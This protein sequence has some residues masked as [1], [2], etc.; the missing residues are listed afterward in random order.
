[1][2]AN[3]GCVIA[4]PCLLALVSVVVANA[5]VATTGGSNRLAYHKTTT[6][7]MTTATTTG[8]LVGEKRELEPN[9]RTDRQTAGRPA[10]HEDEARGQWQDQCRPSFHYSSPP[11]LKLAKMLAIL[12]VHWFGRQW[13]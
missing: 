2:L 6:T 8:P 10:G 9:G 11:T 3:V 13:C 1:M 7:T 5:T 4:F 12:A